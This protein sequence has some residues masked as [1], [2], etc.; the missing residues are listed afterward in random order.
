[1]HSPNLSRWARVPL[2]ALTLGVAACGNDDAMATAP[3]T[4]ARI[5]RQVERLGNPLVSEVLL[6]KRNHGFHNAGMPSTDMA[7][8]ATEIRGFI[9]NVAGRDASVQN[10]LLAVLL[11][12]MLVVQTNKAPSTA[13]WLT[14]ALADGYGGRRLA[15]DVVDAGLT[16]LFG[17][18]LSPD[19]VS[20][21]LTT[22]N[23]GTN[24]KAFATTFPYLAPPS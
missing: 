11:P 4:N 19:H 15:D 9:A 16:A 12:D 3:T 8:H 13:G 2:L 24:D 22:D 20:P 1:M 10:T 23:V 7:N 6:A 5:F 14:W 17:P 21:G 18:L